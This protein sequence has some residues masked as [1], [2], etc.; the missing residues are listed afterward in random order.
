M[1]HSM[2]TVAA[3]V[4]LLASVSLGAAQTA[5]IKFGGPKQDPKLP[6]QVTADQLNVNQADGTAIFTGNVLVGQGNMKLAAP[7]VRV[8][9]TQA[10][11]GSKGTI[12]KVYASGGVTLTTGT[13]AA[14]GKDAVYTVASGQVEMTGDV[15]MTQ[16]PNA[17]SGQKLD[18]DLTTGIGQ[19]QGRVQTVFHPQD[20]KP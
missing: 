13:E 14:Q 2:R 11:A 4:I 3:A 1:Q 20:N 19:M 18:I 7:K 6:V 10:V 16:G 8:E 12:S 9:Y 17:I 15:V 5:Q